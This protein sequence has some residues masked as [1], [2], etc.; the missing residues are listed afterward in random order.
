MKYTYNKEV[1][2]LKVRQT[3]TCENDSITIRYLFDNKSIWDGLT[4][5][6]RKLGYEEDET[7]LPTIEVSSDQFNKI[8]NHTRIR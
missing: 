1:V 6:D 8:R 2:V 4:E 3:L 7:A 5:I